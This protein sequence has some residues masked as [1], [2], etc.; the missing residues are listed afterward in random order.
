MKSVNLLPKPILAQRTRRIR[1]TIW[2][3]SLLAYCIVLLA[4]VLA[5]EGVLIEPTEA[6]EAQSLAVASDIAANE[7]RLALQQELKESLVAELAVLTEIH[8]QP[9]W[10]VLIR[11]ISEHRGEGVAIRSVRV[12]LA[13]QSASQITP[14]Q[15]ARGPY[16][17]E[18][19]GLA[20]TQS[21]VT[22]YMVRLE[23]AGLLGEIRLQGTSP[24]RV[25]DETAFVFSLQARLGAEGQ[26]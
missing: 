14:S 10:S 20:R 4:A 19:S 5:V 26:S 24:T 1:R 22:E 15:L 7:A 6:L 3:R 9:D 25:G 16:R 18:M 12:A 17:V 23:R 11:H 13:A 2:T 21:D 8:G